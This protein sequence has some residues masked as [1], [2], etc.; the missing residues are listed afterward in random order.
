MDAWTIALQERSIKTIDAKKRIIRKSVL[1]KI[2]DRSVLRRSAHRRSNLRWWIQNM[3]SW[4]TNPR[5][6]NGQDAI[7]ITD[8][9]QE[10]LQQDCWDTLSPCYW[11]H[12]RVLIK[13]RLESHST[14]WL[15]KLSNRMNII[16]YICGCNGWKHEMN[17]SIYVQTMQKLMLLR[18]VSKEQ[19]VRWYTDLPTLVSMKLQLTL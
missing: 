19:R 6:S 14:L 1:R 13:R 10:L 3:D 18:T 2:I 7:E 15:P 9:R 4:Q 5:K 17:S 12:P 11:K 16:D 8:R